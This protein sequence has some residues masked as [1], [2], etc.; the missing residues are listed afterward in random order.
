MQAQLDTTGAAILK[1]AMEQMG[2][3]I[4]LQK[5]TTAVRGDDRVTGLAFK[6][7]SSL[8][9]DMVVIAAGIRPNAEIARARWHNGR[10]GHRR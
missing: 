6:D 5:S 4:H 10:A 7:G 8:D 3:T 2:V 9:C 1:T